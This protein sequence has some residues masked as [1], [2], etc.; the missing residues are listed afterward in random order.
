M[1]RIITSLVLL[2]AAFAG[3]SQSVVLLDT[4]KNVVSNSIIDVTVAP[5]ATVVTEVLI[6]NSS[7]AAKTY[8]CRRAIFTMAADD[9]TQFCFG[10]SCYGY[11]TNISTQTLTVASHDTIDFV[12]YGFDC[13][14]AAGASNIMRVVYYRFE[15]P[16]NAAD[17]AYFI[18]R[19]NV[20]M[21]INDAAKTASAVSQAW[22]NPAGATVNINYSAGS[23][24]QK[25]KIVLYDVVGKEINTISLNDKQGTARLATADMPSG[26]YF[27]SLIADDKLIA[28]KKLVISH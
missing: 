3:F 7:G 13:T 17:S 16:N 6:S 25:A 24:T 11:T 9:L 22:P 2:S 12:N 27:Y 21:G 18:V 4:N 26:I 28:T 19:Y 8:Q 10:G 23:D 14:F 20:L 5:G 15:D 1:K